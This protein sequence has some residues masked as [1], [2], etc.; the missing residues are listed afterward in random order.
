MSTS[1]KSAGPIFWVAAIVFSTNVAVAAPAVSHSVK[2]SAKTS[3]SGQSTVG[4]RTKKN[5]AA[6][7]HSTR[8]HTRAWLIPPPPAYMPS[9]LP[10]LYSRQAT[11]AVQ[12]ETEV[13][14]DGELRAPENPY[15]KYIHTPAGDAPQ[16]VQS[17]K[18]VT[19]WSQRS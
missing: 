6:R 5:Q 17:R 12:E 13:A 9:I 14:E 4:A 19:T 10:E 7:R 18:G 1:L 8:R 3:A 2:V 15:K 16:P 11:R